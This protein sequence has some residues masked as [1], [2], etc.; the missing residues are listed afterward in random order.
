MSKIFNRR[1]AAK[2]LGISVE[3]IDRNRKSG[4]LRFRK[5]GDRVLILESDLVIFLDSCLIPPKVKT[6]GGF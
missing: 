6:T 5:V 4:K 1:E 2:F 3:S